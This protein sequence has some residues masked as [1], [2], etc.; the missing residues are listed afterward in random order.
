MQVS[1]CLIHRARLACFGWLLLTCMAQANATDSYNPATKVLSIPTL[2]IG[3]A[4]YTNVSLTVGSIVTL[5]SG[6][7]ANGSVDYYDPASGDLTVQSVQVNSN[8]YY[9]VVVTVTA[10]GSIGGVSGADT[11]DGSHLSI[12]SVKVLTN[13]YVDVSLA[14]SSSNIRSVHGG[15]PIAVDD[16]YSP[17]SGLLT[18]PAVLAFGHVY[19][20]VTLG[21]GLGNVVSVGGSAGRFLYVSNTGSDTISA[22]AINRQSGA[23]LPLPRATIPLTGSVSTWE[24]HIDPSGKYLYVLDYG[25]AGIYGF[26]IN[27]D[28]G[29]LTALNGGSP[30][31]TGT[32]PTSMAFDA[33][34]AYAY[35]ANIFDDTIWAYALNAST[36][37]LSPLSGSPYTVSGFVPAPQQI[38]RAGNDLYVADGSIYFLDVFAITPGTGALHEGVAGSPYQLDVGPYSL[39]ADPSGSVLYVANNGPQGYGSIDAFTIN[40]STGVVAPVAGD[41]LAIPAY[42]ELTTDSLGKFLFVPEA[43]AV[44]IY[45]I[46][47][48][49]GVLGSQVA[50]SPI[51]AGPNPY[52]AVTDPTDRFLYIGNDAVGTVSA[53][54]FQSS[55]GAVAAVGSP[56]AAGTFPDFMAIR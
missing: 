21:I 53:Y 20:N 4:S 40:S 39:T 5:P 51:T 30:F 11:Y 33:T 22:Y 49:T 3:G 38:V 45:P 27:Q 37:A 41:P 6:T 23:L 44:A 18:I 28:D 55:T 35:A 52:I 47:R 50:G 12:S 10:L 24:I 7:S 16:A 29:S 14:I 34:G 56:V 2:A 31:V 43:S 26:S 36:G 32:S 19:T 42:N 15:M 9:N 8:T 1:W 54:T 48:S 46:N 17:S 25:A 13:H